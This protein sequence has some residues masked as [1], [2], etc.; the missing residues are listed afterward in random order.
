MTAKRARPGSPSIEVL[1]GAP[2]PD[3]AS[4][5]AGTHTL[6]LARRAFVASLRSETT[7]AERPRLLEVFD[8]LL[9]WSLERPTMVAFRERESRPDVVSFV[10]TGSG[11][12]FWS[13]RPKRGALPTLELVP[14]ALRLLREEDRLLAMQTLNAHTRKTLATGDALRIGFGALKNPVARNAVLALMDRLI[15]A[16]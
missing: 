13:V 7:F 8:A 14:R 4:D 9:R 16:T 11:E 5:A 3:A 1:L 6:P 12:V 10:R 15:A 2:P